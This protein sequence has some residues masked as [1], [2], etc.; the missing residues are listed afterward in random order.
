MN[1]S[2][3]NG[4]HDDMVVST[5][6]NDGVETEFSYYTNPSMSSKI[7]FVTSVV[8][9]VVGDDFYYPM[10]R[11][12]VFDFCLVSYFSDIDPYVSADVNG[13]EDTID[14][15][16]R[17]LESTNAALVM[18]EGMEP[19]V[20]MELE[21]CVD[22]EI[23]YRTGIHPTPLTDA[24]ASLLNMVEK[25]FSNFNVDNLNSMAR[26]LGNMSGDITPDKMLEA[27]A[28]SDVFKKMHGDAVKRQDERDK[29]AE[30]RL[31]VVKGNLSLDAGD[32]H[33]Y[34]DDKNVEK[35]LEPMNGLEIV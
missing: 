10:I 24:I 21:D 12:M 30:N 2:V 19:D 16:E 11:D 25:K 33:G 18:R 14:D 35:N 7:S 3:L 23:E 4:V 27:Y 26:V 15:V 22:K 13:A 9:I 5:Y 34:E 20:I 31:N 6:I 32:I 28:N 8:N 1:K 29:K 17:F